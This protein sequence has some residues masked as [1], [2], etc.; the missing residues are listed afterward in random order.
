[1]LFDHDAKVSGDSARFAESPL[2]TS[3][4]RCVRDGLVRPGNE[5]A[6]YAERP[7]VVRRRRRSGRKHRRA[8]RPRW[9]RCCSLAAA[10]RWLAPPDHRGPRDRQPRRG[11]GFLAT[12][13]GQQ[14]GPLGRYGSAEPAGRRP[15]AAMPSWTQPRS[16]KT[17][18]TGMY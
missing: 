3:G 14:A 17:D 10:P 2:G 7:L 5:G 11:V 6:A 15:L 12:A 18:R 16:Q 1:M 8:W 9:P 4:R 13:L